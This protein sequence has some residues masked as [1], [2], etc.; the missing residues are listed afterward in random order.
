MSKKEIV[1]DYGRDKGNNTGLGKTSDIVLRDEMVDAVKS[2]YQKAEINGFRILFHVK[3]IVYSVMVSTEEMLQRAKLESDNKT[4]KVFA[5]FS[6]PQ[7]EELAK[8]AYVVGT[9]KE[10]ETIREKGNGKK[11]FANNG[12]A[13]E[14]LLARKLKQ[15]FDHKKPWYDGR[16]EFGGREVKF[17]DFGF[18]RCIS[19][20]RARLTTRKQ[21]EKIGY[22]F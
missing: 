17:F 6:R 9:M 12:I 18:D 21:L 8:T 13:A 10:L 1:F 14:Y 3:G 7:A 4:L 15:K 20:P 16:G 22:S 5:P 19:S 2:A 11:P